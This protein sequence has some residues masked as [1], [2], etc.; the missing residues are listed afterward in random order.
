[1]AEPGD[2]DFGALRER[3]VASRR[4]GEP[5][6]QA[7]ADACAALLVEPDQGSGRVLAA[8]RSAWADAYKRLPARRY[9]Q[10]AGNLALVLDDSAHAKSGRSTLLG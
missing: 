3:L 7:W 1:V 8:T 2:L 10:A 9:H 5:F 4:R 6:E